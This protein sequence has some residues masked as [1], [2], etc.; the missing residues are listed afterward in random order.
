[1][2]AICACLRLQMMSCYAAALD[3]VCRQLEAA[4]LLTRVALPCR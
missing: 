4:I 2:A 1:M 3:A